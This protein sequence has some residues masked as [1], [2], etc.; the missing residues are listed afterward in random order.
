LRQGGQIRRGREIAT[1]TAAVPQGGRVP[2]RIL[3]SGALGSAVDRVRDAA[4]TPR[5]ALR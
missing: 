5:R 3:W 2:F 4:D 1:P